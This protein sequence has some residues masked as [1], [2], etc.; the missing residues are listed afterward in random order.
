MR[1]LAVKLDETVSDS[2]F[3]DLEVIL[4]EKVQR[5]CSLDE[6]M[7]LEMNLYCRYRKVEGNCRSRLPESSRHSL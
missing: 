3:S 5:V 4:S 6:F 2:F 7:N 1:K